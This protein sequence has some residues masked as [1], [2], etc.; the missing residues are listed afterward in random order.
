[1]FEYGNKDVPQAYAIDNTYQNLL[2]RGPFV[3]FDYRDPQRGNPQQDY[4]WQKL[5]I[6]REAWG[7]QDNLLFIR[8]AITYNNTTATL[9][10]KKY[11]FPVNVHQ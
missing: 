3:N 9:V 10:S 7:W 1:M 4:Y 2:V 11:G 6:P 5:N 8:S